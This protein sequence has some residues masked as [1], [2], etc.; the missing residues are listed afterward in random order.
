[1]HGYGEYVKRYAYFGKVFADSG[2]DF[3]GM[4]IKGFGYSGGLK[5][6]IDSEESLFNDFMI[7]TEKVDAK[8]GG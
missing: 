1:M 7:Y 6:Y 5:G 4:D 2:Y 3:V 8:Y